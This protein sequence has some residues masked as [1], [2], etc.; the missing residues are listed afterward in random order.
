VNIVLLTREYP[1]DSSWGGCATANHF[2]AKG[3]A[4]KGNRVHV[5]CQA[6]KRKGQ[7]LDEGVAVHRVGNNPDRYT[8]I[9][10]I[11]YSIHAYIELK[12]ILKRERINLIQADY[13]SAEG[14]PYC[15]EWK[16][17]SPLIVGTQSSARDALETNNYIG[18]I[19]KWK[20]KVLARLADLT[21]TRANKVIFNSNFNYER[22]QRWLHIKPSKA[23]IVRLGIDTQVYRYIPYSSKMDIGMSEDS[24][25]VL[26]VG[27]LEPRKGLHVLCNAAPAILQRFPKTT[28]VIIGQDTMTAPNGGSFREYLK[29]IAKH[30]GFLN[31]LRFIDFVSESEIIKFYSASDVFVL[32]SLEESFGLVTIE[33][34]A[35]GAPTVA[36]KTGIV[37]EIAPYNLF[38]LRVV[39]INNTEMLSQA[40]I[41]ILSITPDKREKIRKENNQIIVKLFSISAY[42]DAMIRC[43]EETIHEYKKEPA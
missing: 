25:T 38:G 12:K 34:M 28:F 18:M 19:G 22:T 21:A 42:V 39:P 7:Y 30:Y 29:G 17:K 41:E 1:P 23:A 9:A 20:L 33:A 27:R 37:Q 8:A 16:R 4:E 40:I 43:Y 13:W 2:L 15:F 35:C 11:D 6:V 32:P 26:T 14:F 5:I 36:T 3:L 24:R 31:C 10:R